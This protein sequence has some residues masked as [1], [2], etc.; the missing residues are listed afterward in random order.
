MRRW[1]VL[2]VML[3]G[4]KKAPS[5]KVPSDKSPE[6]QGSAVTGSATPPPAAWKLDSQPIQ[7]MCGEKPLTLPAPTPGTAAKPDRPLPH[8]DAIKACPDQTSV[9]ATC[10]CLAKSIKAWGDTLDLSPE[11]ECEPQAPANPDAQIVKVSSKPADETTTAGGEAFVFVAKRG[12]TWSPVAVIEGAP[13]VDLSI[14]PHGSHSAKLDR[15][16]SHG[17]LTWIESHHEAQDKDMGES[18]RDGEA[19][20]T[21][22]V[23]GAAPW[24]GQLLLGAWTYAFTPATGECTTSKVTTYT[25]SLDDKSV[26]VHLDHGTDEAGASGRHTF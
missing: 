2:A 8:V 3:G 13:D 15:V 14:T 20:G 26:T 25:A 7:P 12:Q 6:P 17:N 1:I 10:D 9:A 5:N 22:C 23:T 18:D 16:E 24:C 21:V 4:C 19:H 11:V